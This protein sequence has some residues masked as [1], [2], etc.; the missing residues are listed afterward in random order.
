MNSISKIL[1]CSLILLLGTMPAIGQN[2]ITQNFNNDP[3]VSSTII[4]TSY[5]LKTNSCQDPSYIV[6]PNFNT[7]CNG[8]V[9]FFP[10]FTGN[11]N[12]L[13]IDNDDTSS[14]EVY[15]ESGLNLPA[16]NYTLSLRGRTRFNSTNTNGS[17]PV[18]LD[19]VVDGN[20]VGSITIGLSSGAWLPIS[21]A[22]SLNNSTTS[23]SFSLVQ[24]NQGL[25]MDY[26]LDEIILDGTAFCEVPP[27]SFSYGV[28][29]NDY[30]F[31]A[32]V[33]H[34]PNIAF[35]DFEWDF[36]DNT[37][38]TGSNACHVFADGQ[39]TVCLT[40]RAFRKEETVPCGI[41]TICR[42]ICVVNVDPPCF[43]SIDSMQVDMAQIGCTGLFSIEAT[44]SECSKLVEYSV[45]FGDGSIQTGQSLPAVFSH[46][47]NGQGPFFPVVTIVAASATEKCTAVEQPGKIECGGLGGGFKVDPSGGENNDEELKVF[48]NPASDQLHVRHGMGIGEQLEVV[49]IAMDGR[50]VFRKN[51]TAGD[52]VFSLDLS[53]L[54]AGLYN[55]NVR[56]QKGKSEQK[57]FLI[58]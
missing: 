41:V 11:G 38:A 12:F 4:T 19:I 51:L 36:G 21:T 46:V 26:A 45:D 43:C 58:E 44:L 55:L 14:G 49:V 23:G 22:F 33:G 37:S 56:D 25:D 5:P 32:S 3:F 10:P 24:T 42:D 57:K 53:S 17:Q 2:I 16:G 31:T 15:G 48:P 28:D 30:C 29:V 8:A 13:I 34:D 35:Y 54:A 47:Y 39:Y 20:V 9:N 40:V 7:L 27:V 52:R 1:L 50:E 6:G 18:N